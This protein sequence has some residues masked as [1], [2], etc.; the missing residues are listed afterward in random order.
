MNALFRFVS[1]IT[2][3]ELA[4]GFYQA[5]LTT[6]LIIRG[7]DDERSG[8]IEKLS[9]ELDNI[10]P[11]LRLWVE[12]LG[13]TADEDIQR[14]VRSAGGSLRYG[15]L[16]LS[17]VLPKQPRR[18]GGR[19]IP[20]SRERRRNVVPKDI[21]NNVRALVHELQAR[22]NNH[23]PD[24]PNGEV[25]KGSGPNSPTCGQ[26]LPDDEIVEE[27]ILLEAE[28]CG[29]FVSNE[30]VETEQLEAH[31]PIRRI[32]KPT[33]GRSLEQERLFNNYLQLMIGSHYKGYE[34]SPGAYQINIQHVTF[35]IRAPPGHTEFY[36]K[37]ELS[38]IGQRHPDAYAT[39]A[40]DSDPGCRFALRVSV[41]GEDGRDSFVCYPTS[42]TW[43]ATFR[44]NSFADGLS[45]ELLKDVCCRPRR[46]VFIDARNQNF[47]PELKCFVGGAYTDD[48]G[49]VI[50]NNRK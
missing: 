16:V 32:Q 50:L 10:D 23:C 17:L 15:F 44:A 31:K 37:A 34:A 25:A 39:K 38:P 8:R 5:A 9:A 42:D 21:L 30:D 35:R 4:P 12:R 47:P 22:S 43:Q 26:L 18:H 36:A 45:G 19:R 33:D 24:A 28:L 48:D 40:R 6:A 1:A 11:T 7:W 13:F 2:G 41:R 29:M 46:F 27:D 49:N 3:I 20:D 14:L